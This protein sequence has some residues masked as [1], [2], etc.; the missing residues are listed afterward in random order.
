MATVL[1]TDPSGFCEASLRK[2]KAY[3]LEHQILPSENAVIDRL[4]ERRIELI[5]AYAELYEKL[6][7]RPPALETVLDLLLAT[8][9]FWNPDHNAKARA[10]RDRL[11]EVNQQIAL[12]AAALANLLEERDELQNRSAFSAYTHYHPLDLVEAASTDN[13]LFQVHVKADLTLLHGQFDLKYWPSISACIRV[14][15]EDAKNARVEASDPLTE[16]ATRA[17]RQS[18]A[19]FFKALFAAIEENTRPVGFLPLDFSLSDSSLASFANCA[20][21][22]PADKVVDAAYVKRLRQRERERAVSA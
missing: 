7:R 11:K 13:Y 1:A 20:L 15:A 16:A 9:A 6:G 21:D 18:P 14:L 22:L 2:S 8:A 3:N 10:E 17:R 19:D 4:L 5:D 12:K